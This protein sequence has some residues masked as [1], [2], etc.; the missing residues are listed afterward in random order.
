[1]PENDNEEY[2]E[3]R[4]FRVVDRRR[5]DAEGRPKEEGED[6]ALPMTASTVE[7]GKADP[8]EASVGE[9]SAAPPEAES[10]PSPAEGPPGSI[11]FISF[12]ASL[13]TNAMA[14]LG[15]LPPGYGPDLPRNPQLARE[16]IDILGMLQRKTQGNL[17]SDEDKAFKRLLSEV[18][19]AFVRS[20]EMPP[21][22]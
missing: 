9:T 6:E 3:S 12:V 5:F 22:A 16:Y 19:M 10:E 15:A 4:G 11:D 21:P 20:G 18:R 8:T 1:M 14:A 2:E 17:T 7:L 13:A